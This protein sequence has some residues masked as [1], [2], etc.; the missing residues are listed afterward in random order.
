M[1]R[2][3]TN[4]MHRLVATPTTPARPFLPLQG[5]VKGL[6]NERE[7]TSTLVMDAL[8][9]GCKLLETAGRK[10]MQARLPHTP[11]RACTHVYACVDGFG[12]RGGEVKAE[13]CRAEEGNEACCVTP[14]VQGTLPATC[15]GGGGEGCTAS[16]DGATAH[17]GLGKPLGVLIDAQHGTFFF[18]GDAIR[19]VP[20]GALQGPSLHR[21]TQG[22]RAPPCVS[23]L[24]CCMLCRAACW[25]A[26]PLTPS[27][28][29][30]RT[31]SRASC[32]S[33][34]PRCCSTP[35]RAITTGPQLPLG[36]LLRF[37]GVSA[38]F[39]HSPAQ[40]LISWVAGPSQS[41]SCMPPATTSHLAAAAATAGRRRV[42]P[43]CGGAGRVATG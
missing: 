15:E 35:P 42:Q 25:S 4:N 21:R 18:A 2:L 20:C 27:P 36:A 24:T 17:E 14:V 26:S 23:W 12:V 39:S 7:V 29:G 13:G 3:A 32:R 41:P 10:Y 5:V 40:C 33:G 11:P 37:G 30:R 16:P 8:Y 31:S 38:R 43:G 19:W 6:F 28:L 34:W 9:C 1:H 22:S